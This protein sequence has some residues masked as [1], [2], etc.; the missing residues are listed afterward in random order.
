[1]LAYNFDENTGGTHNDLCGANDG[2]STNSNQSWVDGRFFRAVDFAGQRIDV[3]DVNFLEG[4]DNASFSFHLKVSDDWSI[5][6]DGERFVF[7]K[8]S[9]TGGF[10]TY[11]FGD[12]YQ[13]RVVIQGHTGGATFFNN[14]ASDTYP[15]AGYAVATDGAWH[16]YLI[17]YDGANWKFYR[18]CTQVGSDYADT[19]TFETNT[20]ILSLGSRNPEMSGPSYSYTGGMD[21]FIIFDDVVTPSECTE[22]KDFGIDG[23]AG[24]YPTLFRS[25]GTTL[26]GV[27]M[28]G[29]F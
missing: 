2:T 14:V 25:E 26:E 23:Q 5:D 12:N 18:D 15:N 9:G 11:M 22:L 3:G 13:E 10:H 16:H 21:D 28:N 20:N 7:T 19:G 4:K 29:G 8:G 6:G 17:T 27:L 1:M 24:L